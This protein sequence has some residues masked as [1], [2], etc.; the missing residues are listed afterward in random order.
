MDSVLWRRHQAHGSVRRTFW[1]ARL[2]REVEVD[3]ARP[4]WLG[5]PVSVLRCS[6]FEPP[7]AVTCARRCAQAAFR[8]QWSYALPVR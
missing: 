2:E 6:A 8:R 7:E 3:F 4:G 5:E 1:C